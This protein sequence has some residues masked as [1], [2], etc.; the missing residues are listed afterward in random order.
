LLSKPERVAAF[1]KLTTPEVVA[2][3]KGGS[4]KVVMEAKT[5]ED[6]GR[7]DQMFADFSEKFIRSTVTQKKP[8]Y[9]VH[10][11]SKILNSLT[12]LRS[13]CLHQIPLRRSG[14]KTRLLD[15]RRA[16]WRTV[17]YLRFRLSQICQTR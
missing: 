1:R 7:I 17:A 5:T 12:M 4:T 6:L 2:A 9:L 13:C 10:A 16:A 3:E 8:F 11:F 15:K 14:P